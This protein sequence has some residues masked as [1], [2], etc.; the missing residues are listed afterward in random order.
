[1]QSWITATA[2]AIADALLH[3]ACLIIPLYGFAMTGKTEVVKQSVSDTY[4]LPE[5]SRSCNKSEWYKCS[6]LDQL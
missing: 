1:M 2:S 6:E 5:I 4:L 3:L